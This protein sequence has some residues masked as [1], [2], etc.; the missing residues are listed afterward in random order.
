MEIL[1]KRIAKRPNYTIGKLYIDGNYIC[2][3]LEDTDRG[4]TQAMTLEEIKSKKV[5]SQTAIPTGTYK[6]TLNVVSQKFKNR[7][8]A[9]PYEGKL[10]RLL[11]V[12]GYEGVLIHPGSTEKD[13]SGCILVGQNKVVGQVINSTKTFNQLMS[14]LNKSKEDITITI[15]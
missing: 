12:P 13:T 14:I 8:W 4:L 1:V 2:D 6:I 3:T 11:N 9:E 7:V 10:P 15:K 5:Y